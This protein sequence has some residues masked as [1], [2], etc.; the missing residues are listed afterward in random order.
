MDL[1]VE[2]TEIVIAKGNPK[3]VA[4]CF[5][6]IAGLFVCCK[7]IEKLTLSVWVTS[8]NVVLKQFSIY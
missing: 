4:L 8:K 2:D 6:Y 1:N 7:S 3:T 5:L